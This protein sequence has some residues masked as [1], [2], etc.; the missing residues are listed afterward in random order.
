MKPHVFIYH[1]V[2][3]IRNSE[4]N[5][6]DVIRKAGLEVVIPDLYDGE[7]FDDYNSAMKYLTTFGE[8]G[9]EKIA[10]EKYEEYKRVNGNNPVIF[11]GFSNGSNIAEWMSL[12]NPET[13]GTILFHGGLPVKIFGY[14]KWPSRLPIQIYY[15]KNDPW[16]LEDEE[17]LQEFLKQLSSSGTKL[18][19]YEYDGD[20]HLFTDSEL[21][22]EYNEEA[23]RD[24]YKHVCEFLK[25]F[26]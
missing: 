24:A 9:L 1:S 5:L 26:I 7:V 12:K 2:L 4:C 11:A 18:G 23:S 10:L 6:A 8:D 21:T 22:G 3:G 16:R 20:G 13:V 19:F 25:R 17:F 15:S 14:E